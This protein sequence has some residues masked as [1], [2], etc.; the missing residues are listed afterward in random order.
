[1]IAVIS[2][3]ERHYREWLSYIEPQDQNHFRHISRPQDICGVTFTGVI[4]IGPYWRLENH[5]ELYDQAL[6][7]I[8]PAKYNSI[9]RSTY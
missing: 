2:H 4:R 9:Q 5:I 8:R 7:R 3:T 6:I 1:M